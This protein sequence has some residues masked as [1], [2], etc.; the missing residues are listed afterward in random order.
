[1]SN[2]KS[3]RPTCMRRRMTHEHT[4]RELNITAHRA[5]A[6]VWDRRGWN[7]TS[8]QLALSSW[9]VG[10]GGGAL[11]LQG[12]RQ[13][14]VP[15]SILAG[16]G[17]SLAWWALSGEGDLSGVRRRLSHLLDRAGWSRRADRLVE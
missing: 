7:G 11:A 10:I 5:P 9:L 16:F 14:S 13:R 17:T 12:L 1:M 2:A 4:P 6:S 8:E 15:G 3:C